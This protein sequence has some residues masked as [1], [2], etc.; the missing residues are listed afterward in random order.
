M[1]SQAV[2]PANKVAAVAGLFGKIR[3]LPAFWMWFRSGLASLACFRCRAARVLIDAGRPMSL[4]EQC[5]SRCRCA[6]ARVSL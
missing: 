2:E 6:A 1:R 3:R 5:D 4:C